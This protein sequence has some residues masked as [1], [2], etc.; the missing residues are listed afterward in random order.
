MILAFAMGLFNH[1]AKSLLMVKPWAMQ[2]I[3][4]TED[5]KGQRLERF[6]KKKLPKVPYGMLQKWLRTGQI[7]VDGKRAKA[8]Y[9]LEAAQEIRLPPFAEATQRQEKTYN[10][11][12]HAYIKKL[13]IYEDED[14]I[15]LNKP[16]DIAV[17][18]GT[19]TKCHI[20]YYLPLLAT[21]KGVVPRLVHRLD[22]ETSGVL[23]LARSAE[24]AR[25]LGDIFKGR[26]VEKE[27]WALTMPTPPD[28]EG[29]IRA[30]VIKGE[31][32]D[33]ERM[34]VNEEFGKKA[35]TL[36]EV[37]ERAGDKVAFVK[38]FPITGRTHQIRIHAAHAGFPLLGD[39]KYGGD[40]D[41]LYEHDLTKRVHLHAARITF[42]HPK[43][44]KKTT[45]KAPLADDLKVSWKVFGF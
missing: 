39:D 29:D 17:Q 42:P 37:E 45:I 33:T 1:G 31:G 4:T 6:L 40:M 38:F 41:A 27:Y 3:T 34:V 32:R 12:D 13:V 25:K 23:I 20:D 30:A 11:K 44:G 10:E 24:A 36:Y 19:N 28:M 26:E 21:K 15:A 43:N 16:G 22:K 18:G 5:D 14:V 9:T 35:R 7:R 2:L 8:D